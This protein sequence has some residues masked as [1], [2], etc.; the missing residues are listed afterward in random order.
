MVFGQ[1]V[2]HQLALKRKA[3][4]Q[5]PPKVESHRILHLVWTGPAGGLQHANSPH[6]EYFAGPYSILRSFRPRFVWMQSW[7][8][9][10]LPAPAPWGDAGLLACIPAE[11]PVNR[12]PSQK[13]LD[14][15]EPGTQAL[16]GLNCCHKW[17][18]EVVVG[19]GGAFWDDLY[20]LWG[21][22]RE[23]FEKEFSALILT[24]QL[25]TRLVLLKCYNTFSHWDPCF[26]ISGIK[27]RPLAAA[28]ISPHKAGFLAHP[29]HHRCTFIHGVPKPHDRGCIGVSALLY[30]LLGLYLFP[31]IFCMF[32]SNEP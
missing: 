14:Q 1:R 4:S 24:H 16:K 29:L 22:G 23:S 28:V 9:G 10:T 27:N 19:T 25:N 7:L 3:C 21:N 5:T 15:T 17:T 2:W 32:I 31:I 12:H 13:H 20:L 11:S 6:L 26:S 18:M 30:R 8:E